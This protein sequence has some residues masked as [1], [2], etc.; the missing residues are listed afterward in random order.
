MTRKE[1]IDN[2][3]IIDGLLQELRTEYIR[4]LTTEK[5]KEDIAN[6]IRQWQINKKLYEDE[7]K[8][9]Q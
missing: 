4:S 1:I 8:K 7:L 3:K 2:I 9:L 6:K 5:K